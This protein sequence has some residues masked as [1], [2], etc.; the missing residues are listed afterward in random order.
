MA[1]DKL[2]LQFEDWVS[3]LKA[4]NKEVLSLKYDEGGR[5]RKRVRQKKNLMHVK[6]IVIKR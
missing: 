1:R 6:S 4:L 2:R 3:D 5:K